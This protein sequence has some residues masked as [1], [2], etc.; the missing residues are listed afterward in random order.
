MEYYKYSSLDK[1]RK[2]F[3]F[4]TM[5]IKLNIAY[6]ICSGLKY[7]FDKGVIHNDLKPGNILCKNLNFI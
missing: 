3:P 1:F 4:M 5:H 6:Q 7:F 2:N